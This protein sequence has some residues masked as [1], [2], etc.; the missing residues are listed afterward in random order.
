[1]GRT[2]RGVGGAKG[3][4][5]DSVSVA[6]TSDVSGCCA[7]K[8]PDL[9][10][11][12]P[13]YV[14]RRTP[15]TFAPAVRSLDPIA[16]TYA[17][18]TIAPADTGRDRA[19]CRATVHTAHSTPQSMV[20][21]TMARPCTSGP[22]TSSCRKRRVESLHRLSLSRSAS[23][24]SA[25][26]FPPRLFSGGGLRERAGRLGQ[27]LLPGRLSPFATSSSA[28]PSPTPLSL[29]RRPCRRKQPAWSRRSF[30]LPRVT[31]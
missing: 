11:P 13:F 17:S 3:G 14:K 28:F 19:P 24:S 8:L 23:G 2:W 22:S 5:Q 20:G 12:F 9:C 18:A 26:S 31:C 7:R 16:A 6:S 21:P 1:M 27:A 25:P 30:S 10:F 29:G 15:V 4:S